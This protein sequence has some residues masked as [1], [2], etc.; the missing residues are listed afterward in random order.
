MGSTKQWS[1]STRRCAHA[2]RLERARAKVAAE[3]ERETR[4]EVARIAVPDDNNRTAASRGARVHARERRS[5]EARGRARVV[6]WWRATADV[7]IRS[8]PQACVLVRYPFGVGHSVNVV[9]SG[10]SPLLVRTEEPIIGGCR[11]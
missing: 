8:P 9:G 10:A 4:V 2:R 7:R 3:H 11:R 6:Q 5:N 1:I